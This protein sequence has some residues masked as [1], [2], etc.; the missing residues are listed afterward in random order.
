M[1]TTPTHAS[2]SSAVGFVARPV[3]GFAPAVLGPNH[4]RVLRAAVRLEASN[5][6]RPTQ[7]EVADECGLTVRQVGWA[8]LG[9]A[10]EGLVDW[11]GGR[12][13]R[14]LIATPRGMALLRRDIDNRLARPQ[15]GG[16]QNG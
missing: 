1:S 2:A 14:S 9:L 3:D 13:K 12:K 8:I 4:M 11:D 5:G 15:L 10:R 16:R 6:Y 7:R